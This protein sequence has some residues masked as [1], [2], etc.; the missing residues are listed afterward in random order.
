LKRQN[1]RKRTRAAAATDATHIITITDATFE[2][3]TRQNELVL[4]D[5]W[6]DRCEYCKDLAP[7][8]ERLAADYAGRVAFGKLDVDQNQDTRVRFNVQAFPTL[9]IVKNGK[10]VDRI[11]GYVPRE[12]VEAALKKQLSTANESAKS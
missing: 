11:V 4:I 5:F 2:E 6:N 1:E 12:R 10:E 8:I 7:I 3:I 9:L